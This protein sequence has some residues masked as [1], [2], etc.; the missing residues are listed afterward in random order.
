[1]RSGGGRP[2]LEHHD[3]YDNI[4]QLQTVKRGTTTTESYTYDL[5]GNRLTSL[6]L[7]PY[8]YNSSNEL[9]STPSGSYTYDNNRKADPRGAQYSWDLDNRLTQLILQ[10]GLL[11]VAR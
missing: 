7:S 10:G 2:A 9:T 8:I 4:Y 11:A 1:V 6:N 3:A 5:V